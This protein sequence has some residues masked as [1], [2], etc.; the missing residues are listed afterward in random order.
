MGH[1]LLLDLH[2]LFLI[3]KNSFVG[4]EKINAFVVL[5]LSTLNFKHNAFTVSLISLMFHYPI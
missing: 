1:A 5:A 3:R 2:E 4:F